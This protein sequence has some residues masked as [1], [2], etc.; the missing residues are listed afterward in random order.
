[1]KNIK[2]YIKII[3]INILSLVILLCCLEFFCLVHELYKVYTKIDY[4]DFSKKT[5]YTK[6]ERIYNAVQIV[7]NNYSEK[8]YFNIQNFRGISIPT[9]SYKNV[10]IKQKNPNNNSI[11]LF[12]CSFTYGDNLNQ[13]ETF[14]DILSRQTNKIV[15]NLGLSGGSP[16]E[17]LYI[18]R[19]NDL[20]ER[21]IKNPYPY[22]NTPN[23]I[24]YT[25]TGDIERRLYQ[26]IRPSV[27]YFIKTNDNTLTYKKSIFER[28]FSSLY[29]HIN[30]YYITRC[31]KQEDKQ[32]RLFLYFKEIHKEIHKYYP[33]SKFII[34]VYME[35]N[36]LDWNELKKTGIMVI[37]AKDILNVNIM[38]NEYIGID[39]VHPNAKAWEVIVPALVKELNL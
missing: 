34:F 11:I 8:E 4:L 6:I 10:Q 21:L 20:R 18:L 7:K 33:N 2:K 22:K 29:N 15:Y 26:N 5:Y 3:T 39:N 12:G 23:I 31:I 19:N 1:M 36:Y 24:I 35:D 27:P 14:S 13:N 9:H 32:K 38:D 28:N 30:N 16:R 17:T 25:Y 37:K